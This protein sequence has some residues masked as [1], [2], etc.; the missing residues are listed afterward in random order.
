MR[1]L[2]DPSNPNAAYASRYNGSF[3][4]SAD[5]G[6]SFQFSSSPPS[7]SPNDARGNAAA[8]WVAPIAPRWSWHD[9][10]CGIRHVWKY[11]AKHQIGRKSHIFGGSAADY[12]SLYH[13]LPMMG[14][15]SMPAAKTAHTFP[16]MPALPAEETLARYSRQ[17][18]YQRPLSRPSDQTRLDKYIRVTQF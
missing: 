3:Y 18:Q 4:R 5:G 12:L 10:L 2:I 11:T 14:N 1:C 8:A 17:R 15:T 13:R 9:G 16:K 6:N 7:A